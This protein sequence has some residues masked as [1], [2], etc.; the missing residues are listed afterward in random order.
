M[1]IACLRGSLLL[2]RR[3]ATLCTFG[4]KDDVTFG[5]NGRDTDR[6][7]A[8]LSGAESDV[9]ECSYVCVKVRVKTQQ[10][11]QRKKPLTRTIG[12]GDS[13]IDEPLVPDKRPATERPQNG[14]DFPDDGQ[15]RRAVNR[16]WLS[17]VN[18]KPQTRDLGVG[19][20]NVFATAVVEADSGPVR[21][22]EREVSTEQNT[23]V[24]EKEIKT[25]FLSGGSGDVVGP[26]IG[27]PQTAAKPK[28]TRSIGVGEDKVFD[29]ADSESSS[30]QVH[31]KELRT[32]YI[33][34]AG[35]Q[36]VAPK[37]TRNVGMLLEDSSVIFVLIYFL[38]LVLVSVLPTTK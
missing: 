12:T 25:V 38:V 13:T 27:F 34:G 3:C 18:R 29:V 17:S 35:G 30:L 32:V 5:R 11:L 9:Y 28:Q 1:Q 16:E 6:W 4:F 24:K 2:R 20:G 33:D 10:E 21:I 15:F 7:M 31:A 22:H 37:S 36:A 14:T 19:D 26:M 23:E 8:A